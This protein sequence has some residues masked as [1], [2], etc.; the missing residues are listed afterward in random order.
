VFGR[1]H[2]RF[3][4][5]AGSTLVTGA[6]VGL[7]PTFITPSQAL[8]LCSIGTLFA[9]VIV[10]VGVMVLRAREPDRPRPFRCPGYPVT[11]VLSIGA[12]LWLML[13]LPA[14][15]W[16]RFGLWLAVGMVIYMLYGRNRSRLARV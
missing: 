8:E 13:G 1:V 7:A 15:N 11:P 14:S 3:R 6:F 10:S 2:P 12:C 4:T 16:W 9:F 5:P